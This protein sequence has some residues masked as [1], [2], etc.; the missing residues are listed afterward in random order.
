MRNGWNI[1]V[2]IIIN[3]F[4]EDDNATIYKYLISNMTEKCLTYLLQ[5]MIDCIPG[6][7]S[8]WMGKYWALVD[9]GGTVI[10]TK[11]SKQLTSK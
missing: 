5:F 11:G 9:L 10:T 2:N 1:Y 3:N 6:G 7:I 8:L 4:K